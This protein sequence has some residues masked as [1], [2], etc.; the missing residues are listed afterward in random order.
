[1]IFDIAL[2]SNVKKSEVLCQIVLNLTAVL[3]SDVKKK[4]VL[5]QIFCSLIFI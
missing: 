2:D 5:C 3:D 1:M 4:P